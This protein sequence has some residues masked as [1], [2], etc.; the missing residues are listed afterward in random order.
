MRQRPKDSSEDTVETVDGTVA[1]VRNL[2]KALI[3]EVR[4][5]KEWKKGAM[6]F[7]PRLEECKVYL[8]EGLCQKL[9]FVLNER[10]LDGEL[11]AS[12][13]ALHEK[14]REMVLEQFMNG[15]L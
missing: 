10:D 9:N 13:K 5:E 7:V 15:N 8:R 2:L 1:D 11:Q 3:G 12:L 4:V 14:I 6:N